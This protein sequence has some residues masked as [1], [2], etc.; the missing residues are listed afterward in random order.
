MATVN[1][2]KKKVAVRQQDAIPLPHDGPLL[3]H[4]LED[5]KKKKRFRD[6]ETQELQQH[7]DPSLNDRNAVLHKALQLLILSAT[8][9]SGADSGSL[10]PEVDVGAHLPAATLVYPEEKEAQV[11]LQTLQTCEQIQHQLSALQTYKTRLLQRRQHNH[12]RR[13]R[14]IPDSGY[15]EEDD[16]ESED[17]ESDHQDVDDAT[18]HDKRMWLCLAA[19]YRIL[20]EWAASYQTPLPLRKSIHSLL[21]TVWRLALND[22]TTRN[23]AQ[24]TSSALHLLT[25]SFDSVLESITDQGSHTA[26]ECGGS[27]QGDSI[28]QYLYDTTGALRMWRKPVQTLD[29]VLTLAQLHDT[30]AHSSRDQSTPEVEATGQSLE[31]DHMSNNDN[32]GHVR[33]PQPVLSTRSLDRVWPYLQHL[34]STQLL[35]SVQQ[36]RMNK[37]SIQSPSQKYGRSSLEA[38]DYVDNDDDDATLEQAIQ[39]ALLVKSLLETLHHTITNTQSGQTEAASG[40]VP[41]LVCCRVLSRLTWS[42]LAWPWTP[43]ESLVVVAMA[44]G[45]LLSCVDL[46]HEG[47][48]KEESRSENKQDDGDY[49]FRWKS[50][51]QRTSNIHN[52]D[53][54]FH[55]AE[56]PRAFWLQ[57]LLAAAATDRNLFGVDSSS[58]APQ[59]QEQRKEPLV[60]VFLEE[61]TELVT[62][63]VDP[64]VRLVAIKGLRTLTNRCTT[65]IW[66]NNR[67]EQQDAASSTSTAHCAPFDCTVVVDRL[68]E[69]VLSAWENPPTRRLSNAIPPL[70]D[71]ALDLS[72]SLRLS[73]SPAQETGDKKN[74]QPPVKQQQHVP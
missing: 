65:Y 40:V 72:Y 45:Q 69:C 32:G 16:D 26:I 6:Q 73:F 35:S 51:L 13:S 15:E 34:T 64:E 12:R 44:H 7:S 54:P 62:N 70:F 66:Q 9:N 20:L 21:D 67:R 60:W 49:L 11:L 37:S 27:E 36:H 4:I 71:A 58:V 39:A 17:E 57:G 48:E 68:L 29:V 31:T 47:E 19:L 25:I 41:S 63:A 2:R 52:V 56:L 3:Y 46:L 59:Q 43:T 18:N 23:P 55:L 24:S 50:H 42:L 8:A 30:Q 33:S 10:F 74:R 1:K 53:Q 14:K 5:Q 22:E 38:M 28:I 61:L